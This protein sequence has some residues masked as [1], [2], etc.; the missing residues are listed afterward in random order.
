MHEQIL[1][2]ALELA[3]VQIG[4]QILS[5]CEAEA[6]AQLLEEQLAQVTKERDALVAEKAGVSG[7]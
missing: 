6:K 3:R 5:L 4:S 1:R 2:R 7:T